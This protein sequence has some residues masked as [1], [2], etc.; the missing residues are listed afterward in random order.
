MKKTK[1][2]RDTMMKHYEHQL[3]KK[4][5]ELTVEKRETIKIREIMSKS[6]P[7]TKKSVLMEENKMLRDELAKKSQLIQQLEGMIPAKKQ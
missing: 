1:E 4:A 5:E 7:N 3:S 6:T 2:D